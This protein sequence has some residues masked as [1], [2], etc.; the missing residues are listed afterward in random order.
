MP[1][2]INTSTT[3]AS[4]IEASA[5]GVASYRVLEEERTHLDRWLEAGYQDNLVYMEQ[6]QRE[7]ARIILPECQSLVVCLFS[8]QKW[9][10]HT[11][12]RKR[13]KRLLKLLQELDPKIQGR[14]VVDTAPLLERAWGIEAGLGWIGR[15]SM[16]I[17]PDLG[18]NF[19]IGVLLL[20]RSVEELYAIQTTHKYAQPLSKM[21]NLGSYP[22]I[23]NQCLKCSGLCVKNCPSGAIKGDKVVDCK[24]CLSHLSQ[25]E[26]SL[27]K[28]VLK[29]E[30]T[31]SLHEIPQPTI[32][33]KLGCTICQ[34]VCP[35]NIKSSKQLSK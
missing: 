2:I 25:K 33:V 31:P 7:D 15:N 23:E 35:Q 12:I 5:I 20:N 10:Y 19:N 21:L 16:L 24:R 17:H 3:I 27:R 32:E 22:E 14:G 9:S 13:L 8:P 18:S 26:E 29:L 6:H 34:D 4:L 28:A 1:Q 11:P 30:T